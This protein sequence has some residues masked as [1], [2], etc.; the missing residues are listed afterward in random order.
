MINFFD[1]NFDRI[2]VHKII[3]KTKDTDSGNTLVADHLVE[4]SPQTVQ[5]IQDR[6][7]DAA[8]SS[9]YFQLAVE[10]S[11]ESGFFGY[12]KDLHDSNEQRFM[13][14]TGKMA[15]LMAES[16]KSGAIPGGYLIVVQGKTDRTDKKVIVAIKAEMH[17][18]M[19]F[20]NNEINLIED[21]FLSPSKK[22][23]KFG[24]L[25]EYNEPQKEDFT[26]FE[27]PNNLWGAFIFDQQFRPESSLAEYFYRDFLGFTTEMNPKIQSRR[28]YNETEKFILDNV[29]EL[30]NKTDMLNLLDYEFTQNTGENDISPRTFADTYIHDEVLNQE[31]KDDIAEYL[32]AVIEKDSSLIKSKLFNKRIIFPN[33]IKIAGSKDAIDANVEIVT[34]EEDLRELSTLQDGYT[35]IKI[36]GRPYDK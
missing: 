16:M 35:I 32:P 8:S 36:K 24:V 15:Q 34:N 33:N 20:K 12:A 28:F 23:F 13:E 9:K 25:F 18:A 2:V 10:D 30:N 17:D 31:Y 5:T 11:S 26:E 29:L 22:F 4:V 1:V 27:F 7:Y 6:L 14:Y 19:S 21:V 3:P